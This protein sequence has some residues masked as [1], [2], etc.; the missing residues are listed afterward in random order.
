M[1]ILENFA[2]GGTR[3]ALELLANSVVFFI[4]LA[5][6]RWFWLRAVLGTLGCLIA[7][8]LLPHSDFKFLLDLLLVAAF[9]YLCCEISIQDALYCSA[10][11]YACQ[12]FFFAVF[13][14]LRHVAGLP[15]QTDPPAFSLPYF[16]LYLLIFVAF[17]FLFS[18][19]LTD[20]KHYNVDTKRSLLSIVVVLSIVWALSSASQMAYVEEART[21]YLICHLYAMFC[22]VF[23]LWAQ[24]S[25]VKR[26]RL[27]RE[28]VFR[29][30]LQHQQREQYELTRENI[31][32]INRKCHDLKH[33][34]A[35]LRAIVPERE[36]EK[37]LSEV[38]NSIQIYDST[39]ETGSEV[40]DTVLTEKSLYCEAH[41]ITMTCVADGSQMAFMDSVDV[42][43]IFGN[44]L[45]N[46]IEGVSHLPDPER[47]VIGVSVWARSGL[48]LM[49]VE[50][51]FEG[52]LTYRDGLPVT[53]KEQTAYHGFGM[54]SIRYTAQK[55][56]GHL[57]V[58]TERNVFIL[59]VSIPIP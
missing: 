8:G 16:A 12:H 36:R 31:E 56:G 27:E 51:Y 30:Q 34:V 26:S 32:I 15:H 53:T 45:D 59:R 9:V 41:Q 23:I 3:F 7:S 28:L 47:R 38:E 54:R 25:Q 33:Q 22:C 1:S 19:N 35:A 58:H 37:Y 39:L 57:S 6:R 4:P 44:A 55:Y 48:L 43:T 29:E 46:A 11:A 42:Y 20:G 18:R 17:Y 50:N 21:M 24:V 40:L 14:L 13:D 10:C 49:Q 52:E 2:G 5:K